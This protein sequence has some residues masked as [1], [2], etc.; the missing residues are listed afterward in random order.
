LQSKKKRTILC[1]DWNINFLDGSVKLC[2][3]KNLLLMYNLVNIVTS[4][5][6]IT[7]N[8]VTQIDV[9]V[10]NK[11][12]VNCSTFVLDLGYSGHLAQILEID[13]T[14][15]AHNKYAYMSR[16]IDEFSL[17]NFNYILNFE[18]WKNVFD[19]N[20]ATI[21]FQNFLRYF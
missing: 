6:K 21:A 5:T 1:G 19:E 2:E 13:I 20:D 17:L 10:T 16:N 9:I 3:L 12:V 8:S 15:S 18:L 14:I 4:P 7:T 11:H